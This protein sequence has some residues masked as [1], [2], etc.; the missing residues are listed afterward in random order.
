[1]ASTADQI[2]LEP[3]LPLEAIP[4]EGGGEAPAEAVAE[5]APAEAG[6]S[7]LAAMAS[8]LLQSLQEQAAALAPPPLPDFNSL[9]AS[10]AQVSPELVEQ[11]K[12]GI[13]E[14]FSNVNG[15]VE[16]LSFQDLSGQTIY[17]T[18]KLLTDF[19][20]QLLAMVV[21]FGS[22]IKTKNEAPQEVKNTAQVEKMA[23]D[24]VDKAL[25]S[26][27]IKEDAED[28]TAGGKLNQNSVNDLLGS[29][30]F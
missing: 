10:A 7:P 28:A 25:A 19:Q 3:S 18:V 13:S 26:V 23:Q 1:M 11:L 30:G 29:L 14:I 20:V 5:P 8:G 15:I 27:G 22:K 16:A 17:K 24:E 9:G 6:E 21:G 12:G 2:F 4:K